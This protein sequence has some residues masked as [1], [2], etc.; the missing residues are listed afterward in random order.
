MGP[1]LPDSFAVVEVVVVVVDDDDN[2]DDDAV[3]YRVTSVVH[4]CCQDQRS[5][6]MQILV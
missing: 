2:D 5:R 6:D 3:Y 4:V 1:V